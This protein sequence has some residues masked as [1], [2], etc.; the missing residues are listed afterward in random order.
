MNT[1]ILKALL[2]T[3][4]G[5]R[6]SGEW[7]WGLPVIYWGL[8]GIGKSQI[9]GS[10]AR[11]CGLQIFVIIASIREP[12]DFLGLPVPQDGK[13]VY[14]PPAWAQEAADCD[15]AVIFLD[16]TTTCAPATQAALLRCTLDR[17]VGELELPGGV[18]F[19]CA[20]NPKNVAVGGR[21]IAP[22]LANRLLHCDLGLPSVDAWRRYMIGG[23]GD[24]HDEEP[25]DPQIEQNRVLAVWDEAYAAA[26][27]LW[28]AFVRKMPGSL[29]DMPP[30]G[31]AQA[32]RAWPSPRSMETAARATAAGVVHGMS[33]IDSDAMIAMA[34]GGKTSGKFAMFRSDNKMPD[35][36][37]WLDGKIAWEPD[38]MRPDLTYAVFDGAAALLKPK[39]NDAKLSEVRAARANKLWSYMAPIVLTTPDIAVNAGVTLAGAGFTSGPIATKVMA[40]LLPVIKAAGMLRNV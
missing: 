34:I 7:I 17:V 32:S 18:R 29:M 28:S 30:P 5:K 40:K 23:G 20:A 27:G 36:V 3:P 37:D 14:L 10:V 21:D 39:Q 38:V 4:A 26:R 15:F 8:P 12:A 11:M 22:P 24:A 16:E 25:I 31:D 35:I 2:F 9:V 1:A 19:V 13:L 33:E 6:P